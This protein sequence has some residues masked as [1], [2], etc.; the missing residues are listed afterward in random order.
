VS[1]NGSHLVD[2]PVAKIEVPDGRLRELGDY[3]GLAASIAEV[4]LQHPIIITE[5][6]R[7]VTGWHRLEAIKSLGWETIP[8]FVVEDDDLLNRLREIDENLR[9]IDLTVYEQSKHAAERERVLEALGQRRSSGRL[10]NPDTVSGLGKTTEEVA[11]DAGMSDRS[12][13]R[14]TKIG[15]SLGPQTSAVLDHADLAEEK[16]RNL[17]NSTTQL[18]HLANIANKHGD[19]VA[20][21]VAERVLSE[22][23]ASTFKV[24]EQIKGE[25]S[26]SEISEPSRV[27][28]I[29]RAGQRSWEYVVEH[30]DGTRETVIRKVL[31]EEGFEKCGHC[32]GLGVVRREGN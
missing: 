29:V 23:G 11:R 7:L 2:A 26:Q 3:E 19:E 16:Q 27:K 13:Q 10:P 22:D 17:L 9:R 8:A 28:K 30:K 25:G 20:A 1:E 18:N 21:R 5:S 12:W 32:K 24:Y 15:R 14:R 31:L 6:G 4:G